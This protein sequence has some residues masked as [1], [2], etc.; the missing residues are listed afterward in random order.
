M[1]RKRL[2]VDFVELH[3]LHHASESP[4]YGLWMLEELDRHGYRL[5]ASQLYPKLHRLEQKGLLKQRDEVVNGK[6]RKYY[7]ITPS[8]RR[9]WAG[10]KKRLIELAGE[11][12]NREDLKKTW[13]KKR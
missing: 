12:L 11:A 7:R 1:L 5:N 2:A 4:V 9:Y 6:I 10:Q 13:E 8:G 3:I